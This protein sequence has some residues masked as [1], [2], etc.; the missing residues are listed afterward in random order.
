MGV[1]RVFTNRKK[2][3]KESFVSWNALILA[4]F[5]LVLPPLLLKTYVRVKL[6]SLGYERKETQNLNS[7]L[8]QK[9]QKLKLIQGAVLSPD[10]LRKNGR[11]IHGLSPAS[12]GQIF[13]ED[14]N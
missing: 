14:G 13:E 10:N 11:S 3:K 7:D 6:W 2:P 4:V 9:N 8:V 5:L 1:R 12:P